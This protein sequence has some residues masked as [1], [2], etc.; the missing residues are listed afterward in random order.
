MEF[1]GPSTRLTHSVGA[2]DL[3]ISK[4]YIFHLFSLHAFSIVI[5]TPA[6]NFYRDLDSFG[7]PFIIF[8]DS[9]DPIDKQASTP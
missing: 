1:L 9:I 6:S 8:I 3:I 4:N 7:R 5:H 2:K